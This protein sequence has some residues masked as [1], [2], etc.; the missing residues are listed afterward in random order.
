MANL[1]N[2]ASPQR[3]SLRL[4]VLPHHNTIPLGQ[5]GG[6]AYPSLAG[7]ACR[8]ELIDRGPVE[9]TPARPS[10]E[11]R[12]LPGDPKFW[13]LSEAL[14]E[15]QRDWM[16]NRQ[17]LRDLPG[18]L[19]HDPGGRRLSQERCCPDRCAP[20]VTSLTADLLPFFS[21]HYPVA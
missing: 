21:S 3:R 7:T 9:A 1:A 12:L 15:A 19:Y 6:G 18:E 5:P 2:A 16:N 8:T 20:A 10:G 11:I 13:I 14:E 17:A 4:Y